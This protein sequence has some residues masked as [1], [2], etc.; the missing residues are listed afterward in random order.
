[1]D[2][3]ATNR[4]IRWRTFVSLLL[5]IPVG[6]STKS[7]HGPGASTVNASLGGMFYVVFWCLVVRL[8]F[9]RTSKKILVA[10]VLLAT[11]AIEFLQL[12]HP[13][14]LENL[15][16]H[17]IGRTILGTT[18][19]WLDFPWYF[20]GAALGWFWLDRIERAA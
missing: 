12:W 2:E 11:C 6:F 16:A 13:P 19:D 15:R 10:A 17:F 18:F 4:V 9:M 5:L 3:P 14:L 1:M 8:L 7:Y 20:A